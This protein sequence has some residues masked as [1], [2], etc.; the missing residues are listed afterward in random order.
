MS[1]INKGGIKIKLDKERTILFNLNAMAEFE[2]V[3]GK[4][5]FSEQDLDN[6]T[7]KDVRAM[8]WTG[9]KHEDPDLTLEDV[10][11]MIHV[12]NMAEI[13]EGLT[14]AYKGAMPQPEG[15]Q[16]GKVITGKMKV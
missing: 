16:K 13:M 4:S 14:G 9:L 8:L 2:E 6:L 11:E 12:G 15:K 10:G 1:K 5:F 7:A 3:T